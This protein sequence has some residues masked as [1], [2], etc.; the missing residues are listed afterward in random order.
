MTS[1]TTFEAGDVILARLQFTDTFEIKKRPAIVLYHEYGN[2]VVAGITSNLKMDGVPLTEKDGM[3]KESVIKLNYLFTISQNM[4]ERKLFPLRSDKR[5]M[6]Y[7][8]LMTRLEQ[9]KQ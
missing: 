8:E 2:Y 3:E 1:G 4:I 5:Q 9:L 7:K 6:V